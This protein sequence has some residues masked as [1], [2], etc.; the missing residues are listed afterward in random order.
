MKFYIKNDGE[1]AEI[2]KKLAEMLT[3]LGKRRAYIAM[4]GEMGVGKTVFA[5]GFASHF[6]ITGVKS[7]TYTI[8]N[9]YRG[10]GARIYHF[11][12]Y[13]IEGEDDLESIGY[14]EYVESPAFSIVEWSERVPEYIPLDAV[15]VT[16]SRVPEDEGARV[17]EIS[18][19]DIPDDVMPENIQIKN[20]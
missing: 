20:T 5:R 17:I 6:G 10:G 4:N 13:R 12:L 9:E 16:I 7:P 14:H 8:V 3:K 11:D 19:P 18:S 2:G 1:T 15:K